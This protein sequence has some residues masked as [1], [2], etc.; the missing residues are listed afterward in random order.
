MKYLRRFCLQFGN[1]VIIIILC[2]PV[3][4]KLYP[5]LHSAGPAP[6]PVAALLSSGQFRSPPIS[7]R[8]RGCLAV[9]SVSS[10]HGR[11]SFSFLNSA[12]LLDGWCLLP[13]MC[14]NWAPRKNM[15]EC[16]LY[17]QLYESTTSSQQHKVSSIRNICCLSETIVKGHLGDER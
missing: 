8:M 11:K 2:S 7:K 17:A 12:A 5:G 16:R 9:Y 6:G 15:R 14:V 1:G 4:V 13:K 10:T 3:I